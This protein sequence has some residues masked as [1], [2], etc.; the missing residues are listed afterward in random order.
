MESIYLYIY[1]SIQTFFH[2]SSEFFIDSHKFSELF[3]KFH[4]TSDFQRFFY[5]SR[6]WKTS[7]SVVLSSKF[8][9][10][11]F[12]PNCAFYSQKCIKIYE[13]TQNLLRISSKINKNHLRMLKNDL[14][15]IPSGSQMFPNNLLGQ[16]LGPSGD[17]GID[18]G[19]SGVDFRSPKSPQS[20]Q[21]GSPRAKSLQKV[22]RRLPRGS[23]FENLWEFLD[24]SRI[25]WIFLQI[26]DDLWRFL[27]IYD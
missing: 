21:K 26:S 20:L 3:R 5:T 18:F 16:R 4:K 10:S 27:K 14:K 24:I 25:F 8:K 9:G 13:N 22:P 19:A 17:S 12:S 11:A 15:M 7:K 23:V 2:K 1:L 6:P